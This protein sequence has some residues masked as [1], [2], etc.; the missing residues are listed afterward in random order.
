MLTVAEENYLKC[1][2]DLSLDSESISTKAI[3]QRMNNSPASVTDMIKRL[4]QKELITHV[5]YRGISLLEPGRKIAIFLL[6][7]HRL[8]ECFLHN[9][10]GFSWDELHPIA[11][12]LEHIS[13]EML[14][15]RLDE[16]LGFPKFDPHGEPIPDQHGN[17]F[18]PNHIPLTQ[19]PINKVVR[20]KSVIDEP[21][22]LK[23]LTELSI[24]I[25]TQLVV[26]KINN[27]DDSLQ[28]NIDQN[29]LITIG[30]KAAERIFISLD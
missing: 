16:Y 12:E 15:D 19:A 17:T 10:L 27:Y 24:G 7:K 29:S 18:T 8:W 6:R 25:D 11:E 28:V 21:A 23:Y 30:H 2:Y 1:I 14:I 5:P 22:L 26:M 13:S 9:Q 4:A 20:V 3:S